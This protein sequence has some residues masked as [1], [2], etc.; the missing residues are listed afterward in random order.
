MEFEKFAIMI[1]EKDADGFLS[2]E[3]GS[4]DIEK[5]PEY[6]KS[7][8]LKEEDS[9]DYIYMTISTKEDVKD[10]EFSA[11]YDYYDEELLLKEVVEVKVIEDG[12]NP[13]W[14]VKFEF[15]ESQNGM[16]KKIN[17]ILDIHNSELDEVYETIKDK[18]AE[19]TESE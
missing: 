3:V 15:T 14:E 4:Y 7:I 13:C 8:Y 18:E 2:K 5:N 17:S 11:I 16:E 10:W 12:F 19:Y 1:M 9:K 6:I